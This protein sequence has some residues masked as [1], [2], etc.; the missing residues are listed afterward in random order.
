MSPKHSTESHLKLKQN[1]FYPD[2]IG[3]MEGFMSFMHNKKMCTLGQ[4]IVETFARGFVEVDNFSTKP[5]QPM[6]GD[7]LFELKSSYL[8]AVDS[9]FR[10]F[11]DR[12]PK[13]FY[14]TL[15]FMALRQNP[16]VEERIPELTHL[17]PSGMDWKTADS[18]LHAMPLCSRL[19]LHVQTEINQETGRILGHGCGCGCIIPDMPECVVKAPMGDSSAVLV[20]ETESFFQHAMSQLFLLQFGL[21]Q[22]MGPSQ[23]LF[24]LNERNQGVR[25]TESLTLRRNHPSAI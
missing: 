20:E 17:L 6:R 3:R 13:Q 7:P 9:V 8:I 23:K 24:N 22:G 11:G 4:E 18:I 10:R 5:F 16:E 15:A 12:L 21:P 25:M 19:Y 2:I 14:D 1:G